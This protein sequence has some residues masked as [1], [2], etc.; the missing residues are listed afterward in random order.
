[1]VVEK[2]I[3]WSTED[4]LKPVGAL[5][6][7]EN[8]VM[9]NYLGTV[10]KWNIKLHANIE[11]PLTLLFVTCMRKIYENWTIRISQILLFIIQFIIMLFISSM[12]QTLSDKVWA[13][14]VV[15]QQEGGTC[16]FYIDR[17]F[18]ARSSVLKHLKVY[19]TPAAMSVELIVFWLLTIT[20]FLQPHAGIS[21]NITTSLEQADSHSQCET[22]EENIERQ[23]IV[24]TPLDLNKVLL[25]LV[26]RLFAVILIH[27]HMVLLVHWLSVSGRL[28]LNSFLA[29]LEYKPKSMR[30]SVD[31]IL[32]PS[33]RQPVEIDGPKQHPTTLSSNTEQSTLPSTTTTTAKSSTSDIPAFTTLEGMATPLDISKSTPT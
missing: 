1:M 28:K 27:Q 2:I 30:V 33:S 7:A 29:I 31:D 10:E 22:L 12:L 17:H 13:D 19:I 6:A 24:H 21:K 9:D 3:A 16:I 20:T 15:D 25:P 23:G 32:N 11:S 4:T 5:I 8:Y 18:S 26:R 14:H